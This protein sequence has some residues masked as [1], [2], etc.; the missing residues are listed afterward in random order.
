MLKNMKIGK[1]LMLGFAIT[2]GISL[3]IILA[4]LSMLV[5]MSNMYKDLL[6]HEVT[7]NEAI[8]YA[9]LDANIAARNIRDMLLIPN[10]PANQQMGVRAREVLVEMETHLNE[11]S[12]SWPDGVSRDDFENY[13]N[14][15]REWRTIVEDI[16]SLYDRYQSTGD[17][18][19]IQQATAAI[20]T[21][22]T[23]KLNAMAEIA[24]GVDD[25]LVEGMSRQVK[26]IDSKTGF[27]TV[28]LVG[29][30]V[31]GTLVVVTL[32]MVLIRSI[33]G[34]TEEVRQALL[35]FSE[36]HLDVPVT[37]EGRNELGDMC[38]ALKSSQHSLKVLIDDIVYCLEEIARGNFDVRSRALEFYIGDFTR[39]IDAMR[40]NNLNLSETL[41]QITV[42]ANQ[43]TAGSEQVSTGAQALAQGA[44]EQASAVQ[45]LSATIQDIASSARLNSSNSHDAMTKSLAAGSQVEEVAK[46]MEEMV[47]AMDK[48][49]HASEDIGK[50]IATIENIAFQ[51]N[52]LALNAAVEAARAGNAGKGFA[53]VADEVRNLSAKSDQAAKAT[54]DLIDNSVA[55]VMEGSTIVRKVSESLHK[56]LELAGEAMDSMQQVARAVEQ[57]SEAIIQITEGIDQISSVVQTNSATSEQSAAASEE[58]SSQAVIMKELLSRFRLR[59]DIVTKTAAP[60]VQHP[61]LQEQE[62][63]MDIPVVHSASFSKY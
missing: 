17:I 41:S 28:V 9:R 47:K 44:T 58:L 52:I 21:K 48:I 63:E 50:I 20:Q 46:D 49:S 7:S 5:R 61:I 11:L 53:V 19:Y 39:I 4:C 34:P 22:C 18:T 16:L 14:A 38:S 12:T 60:I 55:S 36:G 57:E 29:M 6:T 30:M 51:T 15:A 56:T 45:E 1:S 23:P 24:K 2:I 13:S 25:D 42:A 43:V 59:T 62:V 27:T 37:F 3:L 8:L 35:G 32:A 54:K 40:K 33:T 31:V 26:E 10:D